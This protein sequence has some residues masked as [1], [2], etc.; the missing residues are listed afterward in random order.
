LAVFAFA[1]FY[2]VYYAT[3]LSRFSSLVPYT[4][5]PVVQGWFPRLF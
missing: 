1:G 3:Y 5:N 2:V 4:F